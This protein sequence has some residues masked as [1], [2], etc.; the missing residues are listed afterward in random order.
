M[1]VSSGIPAYNRYPINVNC[2]SHALFPRLSKIMSEML[3]R[4]TPSLSPH[5]TDEDQR[6]LASQKNL[7]QGLFELGETRGG[8]PKGT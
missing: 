7:T 8:S 2:Y 3:L 6:G 4:L 5:F 1:Q